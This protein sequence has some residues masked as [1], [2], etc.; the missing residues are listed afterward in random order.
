MFTVSSSNLKFTLSY[1]AAKQVTDV[2][3]VLKDSD[4]DSE[5]LSSFIRLSVSDG[6][7]TGSLNV[8]SFMC[9]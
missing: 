5:N 3:L 9:I 7:K 4:K 1:V 8:L 2:S 6:Q